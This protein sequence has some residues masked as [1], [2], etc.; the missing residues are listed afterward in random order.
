MSGNAYPNNELI[1]LIKLADEEI[2]EASLHLGQMYSTRRVVEKNYEQAVSWY[3]KAADQGSAT[4][5]FNL[6]SNYLLMSFKSFFI[7]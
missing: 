1:N 7:I 2:T 6:G 4:A 3:Q 5:Y